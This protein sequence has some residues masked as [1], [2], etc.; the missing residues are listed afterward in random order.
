MLEFAKLKRRLAQHA[1]L[2]RLAAL[3]LG[4][5]LT[6][7]LA[8]AL[9]P[10]VKSGISWLNPRLDLQSFKNRTNILLLGIGGD[11]HDGGDLTDSIILL[12]ADLSS[13]DVVLIS[14]PRDIWVV[15]LAA[16]L[17]TA[18]YYGEVKQEG[19]GLILAKAAAGEI[20]NQPVHYGLVLDFSGFERAVDVLEGIKVDVPRGFVDSQY[21]ISGKEE[22]QPESARWET[23]EFKSGRQNFDGA[24]A[25]K[26]VR[27]RHADSEEGSDYNRAQRQQRVILA[28]RDKLLQAKTL[29]NFGKIKQLKQIALTSVKTDLKPETY[30][31]LMKL[32][33]KIDREQLRTGV[34]DQGS[35]AEDIPA[36]LYNPP[37]G[38]FGQW[39][40]LPAGD[41]WKAVY[42]YIE[43]ILY[44][45][46][47]R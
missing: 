21:P 9:M 13:G 10:A 39:V 14:L 36:L 19:G 20:I 47:S 33:L 7:G 42:Q 41:D 43:E 3:I 46:L 30:P 6:A 23:I 35:R 24:T 31:D 15:S 44:Q 28:F 1:W 29:L 27:S 38:R 4:L 22:A 45:N 37:L 40:L 26:Y 25:L 32:A 16:K 18:Y 2:G 8:R 12:S 5:A 17:N 11:G 34:L